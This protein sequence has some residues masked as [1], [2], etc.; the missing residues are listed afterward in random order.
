MDT[1]ALINRYLER[2]LVSSEPCMI[3]ASRDEHIDPGDHFDPAKGGYVRHCVKGTQGAEYAVGFHYELVDVEITK[4]AHAADPSPFD[5]HAQNG[6]TLEEVLI[7]AA[8]SEVE[9][10]GI[11]TDVCVE[12]ATMSALELG[13]QPIVLASLTAAIGGNE[14]KTESIKRMIEAGAWIK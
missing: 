4:G 9:I 5:G 6:W 10:C 12:A 2:N 13:F 14:G 1:V 3:I 7:D 8:S 11:A